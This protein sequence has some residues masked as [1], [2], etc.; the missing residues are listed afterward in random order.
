MRASGRHFLLAA[1]LLLALLAVIVY[2]GANA[3]LESAGGRGAVERALAERAGMPVR[4]EGAFNVMFLPK[5]GVSGTG[6]VVGEPGTATEL[7]RGGEYAV[8]LALAPLLQRRLSIESVSL[9]GGI[10]HL[11][12]WT[13]RPQ[14]VAE[15]RGRPARSPE[16]ERLEIHDFEVMNGKSQA[17]IFRLRDLAIEGF[18]ERRDTPFQLDARDFGVWAGTFRWD[19]AAADFQLATTGTG[20][21]PGTLGL[22]A[23]VLLETRTGTLQGAW[24]GNPSAVASAPEA[25]LSLAFAWAAGGVGLAEIRL[26]A[27]GAA[28]RGDGCLLTG[29][30]PSL[31][32]DLSAGQLDLD[33]LPD[34]S[35]LAG[36]GQG[37]VTESEEGLDFNF[38][39]SASEIRKSGAIA[40]QAVLQLGGE[41]DCSALDAVDADPAQRTGMPEGADPIQ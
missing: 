2:L 26:S 35:A 6:L 27:G 14:P 28:I 33:A 18:A 40:R 17:P 1:P 8:S 10:L 13:E 11:D 22:Q 19:P 3:W 12:R 24:T 34:L 32:L 38:R 37:A 25:G 16:I 39:L 30:R 41:P 23:E 9:D 7:A 36:A 29:A 20:P 31:E 5:L 21:W 4:L 15:A